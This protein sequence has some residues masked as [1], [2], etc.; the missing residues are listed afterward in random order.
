M[1]AE[2]G[3]A[4]SIGAREGETIP[5][6]LCALTAADEDAP[7]QPS[8]A[9]LENAQLSRVT[10][11]S[12]VL[13]ISQHSLPK[14][15]TDLAR[16]VMLPALKL[17]LNGFELRD[18]PLLGR[19]PPDDESSVGEP[20]TEVGEAQEREGLWFSLS[21]LLPVSSGKAPEFDQSCLVRM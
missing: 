11:N 6:H 18:H 3:V 10:G 5:A 14:P 9:T 15:G 7:P 20:S 17:S 21:S 13:V 19:D 2:C 16:T 8:N 12:V 4:E 1:D